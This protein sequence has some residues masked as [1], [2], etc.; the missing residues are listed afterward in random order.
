[1]LLLILIIA[2]VKMR[3]TMI[4]IQKLLLVSIYF[5]N[6]FHN[7]SK[8]RKQYIKYD[9][10]IFVGTVNAGMG[11][12]HLNSWLCIVRNLYAKNILG[13]EDSQFEESDWWEWRFKRTHRITSRKFNK[14]IT[15]KTLEDKEKLKVNTENFLNEV[16]PYITQYG[17]ENVYNSDQ[18]GFQLEMHSG[19]TL[20][21]EGT[22][23]VECPTPDF[24]R[25]KAFIS[26]LYCIK[27][28]KWKIWTHC[29]RNHFSVYKRLS[30][31]IQI[32]KIYV[33]Q[34]C[35][36]LIIFIHK[37][38]LLESLN[39]TNFYIFP[40]SLWINFPARFCAQNLLYFAE[41]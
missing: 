28:A 8:K 11:I 20:A 15:R 5:I 14:W 23:Q 24:C 37:I 12:S 7:G 29:A 3:S 16:K 30:S 33:W 9:G 4:Q 26:T 40:P 6:T 36:F 31:C 25:W 39:F 18:S 1:M 17:R 34:I 21:I 19:R 27:R 10:L 22:R 2:Q 41:I 35:L 38:N 13:F 32:W